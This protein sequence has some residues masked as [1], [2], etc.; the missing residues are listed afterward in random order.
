LK[1]RRRV[2]NVVTM[3]R[4]SRRVLLALGWYDYRLHRGIAKYAQEH[5]WHLSSDV[6][7]EKV[8]PWGWEG[9]GILAWL[10]AGDDLADFV[11]QSKKPTVDFS[12]RRPQLQFHR[13]LVDHAEVSRVA[14]E[15]LAARGL[16]NFIF[17]SDTD[18]WAF[19]EYGR[20]F[21]SA[22]EAVGHACTWLRWHRSKAF[23]KGKRQWLDKRRWLAEQL[24]NAPKPLGLLAASDDRALEVLESCESVGIAVPDQVSIIGTDNSLLAVEAMQT[25]IS[26]V[27][28]NLETVGFR[29]AELLDALMR[30]KNI[31]TAPLRVP[32][33]SLIPRKSS[34][35]LAISH[36]GVARSLK[37]LHEH[38]HELITV[39]DLVKVAGMSRRSLH[40]AFL[41]HVGRPPGAELHR[42]RLERAKR[43]LIESSEKVEVI[44]EMCGYQSGNSFWVAFKQAIGMSP[45][46]FKRLHTASP[47]LANDDHG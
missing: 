38:C 2:V 27:D 29:G 41:T 6:A 9:D 15:H 45:K 23:T 40:E 44:A 17:Y 35:V 8:I 28:T 26:S 4:T 30:G 25:P 39:E 20:A 16:R 1:I 11:V 7:K 10:G 3:R 34:D 13:V 31:P 14:A 37:F 5:G 21:V 24:K 19:D 33:A 22:L 43:L 46:E 36:P 47:A 18:N 32:P 42:L 12:F